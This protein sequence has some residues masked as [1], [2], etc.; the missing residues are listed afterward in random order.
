VKAA[1]GE[2][3]SLDKKSWRTFS[4]LRIWAGIPFRSLNLTDEALADVREQV[5][6]GA[7]EPL[8]H[9]LFREAWDQRLQNPRSALIIGYA[10]AEV[11]FKECAAFLIPHAAWLVENLPTPPLDKVLIQYVP[12]L[13]VKLTINGSNPFVPKQI[14]ARIREAMESRNKTAHTKGKRLSPDSLEGILR[15]IR[16]LLWLFDYHCGHAWALNNIRPEILD[17]LTKTRV[18]PTGERQS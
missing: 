7:T 17:A 11:G 14:I 12:N 9:E 18:S 1:Y 5:R 13:P 15:A 10:A 6:E 2:Q 3:W 8:G 4:N 16:D